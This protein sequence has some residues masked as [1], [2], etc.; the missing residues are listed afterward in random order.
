MNAIYLFE[1]NTKLSNRF[2][3]ISVARLKEIHEFGCSQPLENPDCLMLQVEGYYQAGIGVSSVG[4]GLDAPKYRF[5]VLASRA[6]DKISYLWV[7][8]VKS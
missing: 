6:G 2:I 4:L 1:G 3:L 7:T 5:S 8:E